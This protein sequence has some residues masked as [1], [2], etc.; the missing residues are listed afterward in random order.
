LDSASRK[1][2]ILLRGWIDGVAQRK[3]GFIG[4]CWSAS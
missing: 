2:P 3:E 4:C 1:I